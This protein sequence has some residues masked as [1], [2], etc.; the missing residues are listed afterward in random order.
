MVSISVYCFEFLPWLPLMMKDNRQDEIN[1]FFP[2]VS[3]S[4][5]FITATKK[6]FAIPSYLYNAKQA[7]LNNYNLS[8][9]S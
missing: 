9:S 2:E 4:Q 1:N 6:Q 8:F 3:F 5:Y 7:N